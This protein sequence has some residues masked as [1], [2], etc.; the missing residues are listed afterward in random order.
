MQSDMLTKSNE[1]DFI[2][3]NIVEELVKKKVEEMIKTIDMCQCRKCVLNACAIA[4]NSLNS[5]YVTTTRGAL[6]AEIQNMNLD[7]Q[8]DVIVAVTNALRIVKDCPLH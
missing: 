1:N 5:R 2:L 8:A 4:L 6:I 3:V 7:Y